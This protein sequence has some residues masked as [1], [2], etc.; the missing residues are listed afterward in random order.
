MDSS[1]PSDEQEITYLNVS[2]A[3]TFIIVDA[4]LSAYYNLDI[5]GKLV[6]A[7]CRCVVQLSILGL[8]LRPVFEMNNPLFVAGLVLL[9]NCLG[10]MEVVIN[11]SKKRFQHMLPIVLAGLLGSTVPVSIIGV[12]FALGVVPF[13]TPEHYVPIAGMLIGNA[14]SG[15]VVATSYVMKELQENRDKVETYLAFGASRAEACRPVVLEALRLAL[16]PTINQM[17]V[18]GLISIPGMMTGALLG[19]APV[20]RASRLQMIIMFLLSGSAALSA[21]ITTI[22]CVAVVVDGCGR[23]RGERITAGASVGEVLGIKMPSGMRKFAEVRQRAR[24]AVM[25]L[26][27]GIRGEGRG[28]GRYELL[29]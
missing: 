18:I 4:A 23:V 21:L 29:G 12:R 24:E 16:T 1:T 6:W 11:K 3:F 7:A 10:T 27:A 2:I 9:L 25:G 17:S 13:W 19:G 8:I 14:I 5:G 26:V 22:G 28:Q 20:A 15:I